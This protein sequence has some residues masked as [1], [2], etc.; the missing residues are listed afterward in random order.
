M[1][2]YASTEKVKVNDKILRELKKSLHDLKQSSKQWFKCF[3]TIMGRQGYS[4]S[5]QYYAF[6]FE[7]SRVVCSCAW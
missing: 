1:D 7:G 5:P 4:R 3:D 6:S 2:F